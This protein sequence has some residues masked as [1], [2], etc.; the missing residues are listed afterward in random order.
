MNGRLRR[1]ALLALLILV[2]GWSPC[3]ADDGDKKP[4]PR[5]PQL[6]HG[7]TEE[8]G[9]TPSTTWDHA[10]PFLAQKVIDLGYDL[11]NPYGV[12]LLYVHMD[13]ELKLDDLEVGFNGGDRYP[14]NFV[15]FPAA[16]AVNDTGQV[17]LD[18]W[19]FPFL[20]AYAYVGR[21]D[22][23]AP[24]DFSISGDQLLEN[25]GID[26]ENPGLGDRVKCNALQ[27]K[28]PRFH[29]DADFHGFNTG[30]GIN[31][32]TGWRSYF[33][34]LPFSYTYT[35]LET[36]NSTIKTE[37]FTPRAGRTIELPSHGRLS[38]FAGATY[39]KVELDITGSVRVPE[40]DVLINYKI[41]QINKDLW[42]AL[43]GF[44]W[45]FNKRWSWH[46]EYGFLGSRTNFITG[47]S[48]RY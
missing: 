42:N 36:A 6:E 35:F 46:A 29:V 30:L 7:F 4:P 34:A 31:L 22:G 14:I 19:I 45:E 28:T 11:P 20:N 23:E 12:Q 44:S 26:C 33:L 1:P 16:R 2:A 3:A 48:Y 47:V 24:L 32:A 25:A 37:N 17:R 38:L 21:I 10:L 41:H 15:F 43:V 8:A 13:Q 18:A 9:T 5:V 39:L 40:S 27:G